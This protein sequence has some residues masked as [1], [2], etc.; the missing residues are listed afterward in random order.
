MKI[1]ICRSKRYGGITSFLLN[2][3]S[4]GYINCN[5]VLILD[6]GIDTSIVEKINKIVDCKII[7]LPESYFSSKI[8]LKRISHSIF[9]KKTLSKFDAKEII[10]IDWNLVL[11][12][13]VHTYKAKFVSFVHTYPT[14]KVPVLLEKLIKKTFINTEIITVSN[15]SKKQILENW[16]LNEDKVKVVYNYSSLRGS[17]YR[18]KEGRN[19]INVV[20]IA[21]CEP[22]KDPALWFDVAK[23]ITKINL[24]VNFFWIGDGTLFHEY[25][26]LSENYSN[27]H[28]C[29]YKD[30]IGDILKN[31]TDLYLQTS[32]KESLGIS[33]LDAMNYSIPCVVTNVGGMPELINHRINGY[34]GNNKEELVNYILTILNDSNIYQDMAKKSKIRYEKI[35]SKEMWNKNILQINQDLEERKIK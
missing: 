8:I 13:W 3:I 1:M 32:N 9:I 12:F 4:N 5:D 31:H 18:K 30:N 21:H 14:R 19:I 11:D 7:Y 10:F 24:N 2:Y 16:H 27:V 22:Y 34:V 20:T 17:S 23:K 33:I 29:G 6:S 15:F 25:K 28:F 35:F 26:I